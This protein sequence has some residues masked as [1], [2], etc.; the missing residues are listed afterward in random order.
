M[1]DFNENKNKSKDLSAYMFSNSQKKDKNQIDVYRCPKCNTVPKIQ[2]ESDFSVTITCRRC[3]GKQTYLTLRKFSD[4]SK[5]IRPNKQCENSNTEAHQKCGNN[6]TSQCLLCGSWV[7]SYCQGFHMQYMHKDSNEN[8]FVPKCEVSDCKNPMAYFCKKI[9]KQICEKCFTDFHLSQAE[10]QKIKNL[11][12]EDKFEQ[13][14]GKINENFEDMTKEFEAFES[15]IL[16]LENRLRQLK[17]YQKERKTEDINLKYFFNSLL[18][19]Y[20]STKQNLSFQS[21]NNLLINDIEKIRKKQKEEMEEKLLPL[22]K[23]ISSDDLIQNLLKNVN[24]FE[25]EYY[26]ADTDEPTPLFGSDFE[27]LDENE[28]LMFI[29]GKEVPFCNEYQFDKEGINKITVR[30]KEGKYLQDLS[31]MFSD[32]PIKSFDGSMLKT[33]NVTDMSYMFYMDKKESLLEEA[34]FINFNTEKVKSMVGLFWGCSKLKKIKG[35]N[36]FNMENCENISCMFFNCSAL[37]EID[38]SSFKTSKVK[39]MSNLFEHCSS[40][41]DI[42]VSSFDTSQ[43]ENISFTF[44]NCEKIKELNLSN[45]KTEKVTNMEGLFEECY[46]LKKIDFGNDFKGDN[47]GLI[48]RMFNECHNLEEVDLINF[49]TENVSSMRMMFKGCKSLKSLDLRSFSS[50]NVKDAQWM[51][52]GCTALEEIKITDKFFSDET[53]S[54][55]IDGMKIPPNAK[56]IEA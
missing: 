29:N 1:K 15:L 27:E 12:P 7:C 21:Q 33:D 22:V 35:L 16:Q 6:F 4:E 20:E 11:L 45:F 32:T 52:E 30:M 39:D 49:R 36:F 46:Q 10:V 43:V 37:E 34:T 31:Y 25:A 5:D 38:V 24:Y 55:F 53:E 19:S 42:D 48:R 13:I 28:C 56:V 50:E 18:M 51:F 3:G 23:F 54:L 44:S 40:L 17:D 41:T 2:I 8:L 9:G 26:V 47:T 14:K